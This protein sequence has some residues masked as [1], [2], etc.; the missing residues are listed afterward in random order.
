MIPPVVLRNPTTIKEDYVNGKFSALF[1]LVA[2]NKG[3][4]D[5]WK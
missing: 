4:Q 1:V 2:Y 5:Q 3:R